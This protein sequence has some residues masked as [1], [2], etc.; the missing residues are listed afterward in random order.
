M[1]STFGYT[2]SHRPGL[3][4]PAH[5]DMPRPHRRRSLCRAR[6]SRSGRPD[7][8]QRRC[9]PASTTRRAWSKHQPSRFRFG[10]RRSDGLALLTRLL[11][12]TGDRSAPPGSTELAPATSPKVSDE[13]PTI[14]T[15]RNPSRSPASTYRSLATSVREDSGCW[16]SSMPVRIRPTPPSLYLL[17]NRWIVKGA[18]TLLARQTPDLR[19]CEAPGAWRYAASR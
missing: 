16:P 13:R 4:P 10:L 9:T 19:D 18:T 14:K 2:C 7:H 1:T 6:R 5:T 11:E 12:L 15:V 3:H 17:G 8:R